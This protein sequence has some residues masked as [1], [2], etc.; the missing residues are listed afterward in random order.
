[1][2]RIHIVFASFTT[3]A[4]FSA[5][6][7]AQPAHEHEHGEKN[8]APA[9]PADP[10]TNQHAEQHADAPAEAPAVG[11]PYP[12]AVCP[13]SGMALGSMGEAMVKVYDGREVRFCCDSCPAKFEADKDAYFKKIDTM[14]IESQLAYYPLDR[15]VVSGEALTMNGEDIAI[16]FV[17]NNRLVR[18]CC[19]GCV[20]D[21]KAEPAKYMAKLDA[22]VIAQQRERYPLQ[23]CVVSGEDIKGMGGA[24]EVIVA[25]RL[26]KLCCKSCKKDLLDNPS[27]YLK[28]LDAAWSQ[29][30]GGMPGAPG[31]SEHRD[32]M[33]DHADEAGRTHEAPTPNEPKHE[34]GGASHGGM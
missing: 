18:L 4:M 2:S 3:L 14:I 34:H 6:L 5:P 31:M 28:K 7:S 10:A 22:A 16:D 15:C 27:P 1:M 30:K 29:S 26:V 33:R 9:Q 8:N 24:V 23:S 19:K 11:D 21:F 20:K 32:M 25:N 17:Y 12:L 13:V